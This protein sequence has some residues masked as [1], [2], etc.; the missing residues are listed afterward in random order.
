MLQP[1]FQGI[2]LGITVA[3][4]LG[5]A[6]L[7]LIQTSVKH[8]IK[9]GI[10]LAFG[11][12]F[13]DLVVVLGA[14]LG[15]SQVVTNPVT[16]MVFGI[17]GGL[18]LLVFGLVSI[19]HKVN[20]NEQVEAINEIK[21]KRPGAFR[22]FLKGFVLNIANPFL[23]A[24][25]IT[26]VLAISSSYRGQKVALVVFFS[27]T[28]GTILL[29]DITKVILANKIKIANNPH[30]K[31]WMNRIVGTIFVVFGIYVLVSVLFPDLIRIPMDWS[32]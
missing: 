8:G 15:A 3:I 21:I 31:L 16:H 30:V 10:L 17:F 25:W 4:S 24:F 6:L 27:G 32:N 19:L 20:M 22:Y 13:S 18:A 7:A 28:L 12:F 29:T 2:I 14:T 5:P 11:I 23:W 26:S 9:T 1:L